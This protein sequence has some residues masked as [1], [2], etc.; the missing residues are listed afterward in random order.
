MQKRQHF[1]FQCRMDCWNIA[2]RWVTPSGYF[3]GLS[4]P[5]QGRVS[6]RKVMSQGRFLEVCQSALAVLRKHSEASAKKQSDVGG[7]NSSRAVTSLP[8]TQVAASSTRS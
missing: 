5:L 4:T 6:M 2:S 7:K 8:R 1:E 3:C